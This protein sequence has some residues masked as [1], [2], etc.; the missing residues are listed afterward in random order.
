MKKIFFYILFA[1][2]VI[3]G[4]SC[5]KDF[6]TVDRYDIIEPE[7]L[8]SSEATI[9]QGLNGVYDMLYPDKKGV[10]IQQN[11]NFK[12]QIH[13]ANYPTLDCQ[14]AGWDNEFTRHDWRAD[15]DF[16]E[17]SWLN[18]Y[19]GVDRANRFIAKLKDVDPALFANGETTKNTIMA[20]VRALRG[21]FYSWLAQSFG[22]VPMLEEGETYSNT[23]NKARAETVEETWNFI[24]EDFSYAANNLDW[25]PYNGQYGRITKGM[26]KAYLA[27]AYMYMKDFASAKKELKDI[28]DSQ[29]YSLEP[30]FGTI[31]TENHWWSRE[32]IFE[33][34]FPDFQ[35]MGWGAAD[36]TD[37]LLWVSCL[38]ASTTY[39]GW[40]ALFIS[41]ELVSSFEPGDKRK[42][43][44]IVARGETNP[45]TGQQLTNDMTVTSEHMPNNS[46]LKLWKRLLYTD[47][48]YYSQ[49]AVYMRYAAVLLNYAECIFETSGEGS[50]AD[51][52]T[53]WYYLD[54]I[55][56]R[57]W[58]NL[59]VAL[60][61][62]FPNEPI[63]YNVAEVVV[64]DAK[65]FYTTDPHFKSYTS[66][67]KKVAVMNERRH[68]FVA[69]YSFWFDLVR[70]GM[71]EEYLNKEYPINS[72]TGTNRLFTFQSFRTV[73]PIPYLEIIRNSA[74]GP[75][76]QNPGY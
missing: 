49:S 36:K 41:D 26:A 51:G 73:F 48:I 62:Q 21:Y 56:S 16:F 61:P 7:V 32:S 15:K 3:Y 18:W 17:I 40:G 60:Q 38:A 57:A 23:P 4:T 69:E 5:K 64:P 2:S 70:T 63:P 25:T 66:D 42:V 46:C 35:D 67:I 1:L 11:W 55:R 75:E 29:K 39:G 8:F 59:E 37:A 9:M 43:Y 10:D 13:F 74:I 45:Y 20:E 24:V 72:G 58:G 27:Q 22:R 28:I 33:V 30:S 47:K 34:A 31:H 14:A 44:S 52:H 54:L 50:D 65:S 53:G 76:N 71:A 68:E 12:P 19:R 6:L